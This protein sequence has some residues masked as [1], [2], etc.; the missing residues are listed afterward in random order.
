MSGIA[1][2]SVR[3]T[4]RVAVLMGGT[5]AEREVSLMSGQGVLAA[6]QRQGVDAVSFDPA[7]RPL[8]ELLALGIDRVFIA[9]HG[10]F[11]EDGT[12]QGALE[13]MGLP[14]T[15]SGVMASAL[16]M[17]K[18]MT[19]RVWRAE[20]IP[21]PGFVQLRGPQSVDR[22][23]EVVA[24]L[25]LPLAV[26][27]VREG[28]SLGL[29]RLVR[30][31]D[32]AAAVETASCYDDGVLAEQF[33]TGREFT[34]ALIQTPGSAAQALPVIEIVPP[35]EGYDYQNKYFTDVVRYDCPADLPARVAEAMQAHA[36]HAFEAVG[37]EG[38]ARV[39][40]M[41]DGKGDPMLLEINTSPGLTSHSLVPMAAKAVGMSYDALVMKLLATARC[42]LLRKDAQ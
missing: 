12:V 36:L 1:S 31:E 39:D 14:Y 24:Q 10:R 42:K 3:Q 6:L 7:S 40:V 17:D 30:L 20:G 19:K 41:W 5:S 8:H 33:V 37:C 35:A 9:L 23:A 13:L 15:G 11:G 34:V 32:F 27:P 38:W 28:S 2:T 21:T 22:L 4:G 25:G 18:V 26:K 16:A 29:T